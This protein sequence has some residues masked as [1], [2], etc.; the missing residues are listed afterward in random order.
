MASPKTK[1][2]K[3]FVEN[4]KEN[5]RKVFGG[6][7]MPLSVINVASGRTDIFAKMG[8]LSW[9]SINRT[10]YSAGLRASKDFHMYGYQNFN[11]FNMKARADIEEFVAGLD[12]DQQGLFN[13]NKNIIVIVMCP[14]EEVCENDEAQI[15]SGQSLMV[16][17]NKAMRVEQ[18]TI[19]AA[20]IMLVYSDR[21]GSSEGEKAP[22]QAPVAV[23]DPPVT[24]QVEQLKNKKKYKKASINLRI[25]RLNS[26]TRQLMDRKN[27]LQN[28]LSGYGMQQQYLKNVYGEDYDLDELLSSD[29]NNRKWRSDFNRLYKDASSNDRILSKEISKIRS[30]KRIN[31]TDYAKMRS[32]LKGFDNADLATMIDEGEPENKALAIQAR[33]RELRKKLAKLT[34]KS[35][36]YLVDLSLARS[37]GDRKGVIST[38]ANLRRIKEQIQKLRGQ[39]GTYARMSSTAKARKQTMLQ[40]V[41]SDIE[42]NLA[43]GLNIS[44]ALNK[45]LDKQPM[46]NGEKQLV[47]QQVIADIADG[48]IGQYA[49]QQAIQDNVSPRTQQLSIMDFIP[50]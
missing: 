17:F 45:A 40:K 43:R 10:K 26:K 29:K 35:E 11:K 30:N 27:Q 42:K 18:K 14:D 12:E 5:P 39:L 38:Q 37:N 47:K 33:R 1:Y 23:I 31:D 13:N 50:E 20:Y 22:A 32:Y 24:K 16:S 34:E 46:T 3:K 19:N 21:F 2:V 25:K 6:H 41:N 28:Q 8:A 7:G 9:N 48:Q 44:Q 49:V 15:V 36:R 4:F